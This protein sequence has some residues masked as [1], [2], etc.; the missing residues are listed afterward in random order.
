VS[1]DGATMLVSDF[2]NVTSMICVA[3]VADGAHV[4]TIGGHGDMPLEFFT[5]RQVWIAR[6]DFV[7]V[8]DSRTDRIQVLTPQLDFYGF[9]GEGRLNSPYGVCAN[10]DVIA[11]AERYTDRIRVFTRVD[12]AFS[13]D[14]GAR[15][16]GDG[17]LSSPLGLCFM[18]DHTEIAVVELDNGRVSVF[19]VDGTFVRHV[20]VGVLRGP[21][22]V[23][24][25]DCDELVVA[26]TG[27]RRVAI[28]S[29]SGGL[30]RTIG[31][32]LFTNVAVHGASVFAHTYGKILYGPRDCGCV[33]FA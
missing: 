18:A 2:G 29:V 11:V 12:G 26:D 23:A 32:R 28:F 5:P 22:G 9:I 33:T 20:G 15:G 7:F 14:F 19:R 8:A 6:D 4:R 17:E 24:C 27:N 3:R 16:H 13:H 10:G 1:N 30:L 31:S 21:R 25:S